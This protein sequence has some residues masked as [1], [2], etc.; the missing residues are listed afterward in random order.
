MH[1]TAMSWPG[2][3][4]HILKAIPEEHRAAQHRRGTT[5]M[6]TKLAKLLRKVIQL[7]EKSERTGMTW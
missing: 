5:D 7:A 2:L 4:E 1:T 6:P 3:V